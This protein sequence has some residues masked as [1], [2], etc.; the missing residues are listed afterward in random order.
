MHTFLNDNNF[1]TIQT[2]PTDK[3]KKLLAKT[4]EQCNPTV[5]KNQ[6]KYLLQKKPLP[7]TLKAQIKIQKSGNLI[8]PVINNMNAP[9]YKVSKYLVNKLNIYL[10][11]NHQFTMKNSINLAEDLTKLKVNGNYRML[12]YDIKDL[13]INILTKEI[14]R[15]TKSLLLKHND[16]STTKQLIM[17][18][19]VI[20]QQ[21]YFSFK[22]HTYQPETGVSMGSPISSTIAETFLQHMENTLM[23]QLFDTKNIAFYT[24]YVDDILLTYNSQR[25]TPKTIHN[26]INEVLPNL[27]LN[28]TYKNNDSI[29]FMDLLII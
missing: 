19:D 27:Q 25:I 12:T 10:N 23:K 24:R 21:Y 2:N 28:P 9:A 17:L 13:C 18:L 7:P 20:L 8:R 5:N 16:A 14:L 3:F 1:Q 26:Y 4:L 29:N 15:I 6:I 11:L 22:N